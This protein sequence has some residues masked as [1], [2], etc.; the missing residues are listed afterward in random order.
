MY[1][2]QNV[3]TFEKCC[4]VLNTIKNVEFI[5]MFHEKIFDL[6]SFLNYL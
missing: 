5:E 6:K 3:L 2:N 1:R 4:E